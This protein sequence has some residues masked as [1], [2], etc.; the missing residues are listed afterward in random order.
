MDRRSTH[1]GRQHHVGSSL[2]RTR[3]TDARTIRHALSRGAFIF[4]VYGDSHAPALEINIALFTHGSAASVPRPQP[5][6]TSVRT[7]CPHLTQK[8]PQPSDTPYPQ[9]HPHH[10]GPSNPNQVTAYTKPV[11]QHKGRAIHTLAPGYAR[12]PTRNLCDVKARNLCKI[13]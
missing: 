1:L 6:R 2:I 8:H 11:S 9:P 5:C 10:A 4:G 13:R 12:G 3:L 7:R